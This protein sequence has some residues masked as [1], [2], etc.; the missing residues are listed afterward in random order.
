M[1]IERL[2]RAESLEG[3]APKALESD[4]GGTFQTATNGT[5]VSATACTFEC[6]MAG[7][8]HL[9][10]SYQFSR[11]STTVEITESLQTH[12]ASFPDKLNLQQ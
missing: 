6:D 7:M 1:G 11:K 9:L 4:A 5:F 10:R 2:E 8:V 3:K 12:F